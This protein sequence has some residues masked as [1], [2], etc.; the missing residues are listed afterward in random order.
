MFTI[1]LVEMQFS[2]LGRPAA[3]ALGL[4]CQ[5]EFKWNRSIN[6]NEEHVCFRPDDSK[7]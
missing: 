4:H 1:N 2:V 6:V 7:L 3:S 5:N